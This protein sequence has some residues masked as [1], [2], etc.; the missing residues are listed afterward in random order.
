MLPS[1]Y[2][3]DQNIWE[4]GEKLE[5]NPHPIM[6]S[7]QNK[8]KLELLQE[9][10]VILIKI[11]NNRMINWKLIS[12]ELRGIFDIVDAILSI[13]EKSI[14]TKV[15]QNSTP[16]PSKMELTFQCLFSLDLVVDWP[17]P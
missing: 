12:I 9:K 10:E 5:L 1:V 17:N 13:V 7:S 15:Y 11:L 6:Q 14:I 4:E 8:K 3:V 2:V 16:N